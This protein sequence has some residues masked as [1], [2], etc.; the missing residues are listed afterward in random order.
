MD[1]SEINHQLKTYIIEMM[2]DG[3]GSDLDD[4]TPLLELGIVDSMGIVSLLTFIDKQLGVSVPENRVSPR[5]FKS[6]AALQ[7]LILEI[8][9]QSSDSPGET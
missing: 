2:L 3:D 5:Y 7:A 4:H 8:S 9:S 1:A 6:I